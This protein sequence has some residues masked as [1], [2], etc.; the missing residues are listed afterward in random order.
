[1]TRVVRLFCLVAGTFVCSMMEVVS[2]AATPKD[3]VILYED[4]AR[5]GYEK[6]S[7]T[8]MEGAV[9]RPKRPLSAQS[10]DTLFGEQVG[11]IVRNCSTAQYRCISVWSRIFAVPRNR[12]A[13]AETY[14][15]A[16]ASL[17]VEDCLRGDASVCQVA[18]ISAD[19]QQMSGEVCEEVKGGRGE[20]SKPG[21]IL[22]FIYN[23]DVGVTAYGVTDKP[24]K[25][26]NQRL[27]VASQMIL[28]GQK[29]LLAERY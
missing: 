20:S 11:H 16:G 6:F 13:P 29:G 10:V 22:Y 24:A 27:D 21:P 3:R 15:V 26:K 2:S 14:S 1:M 25:T 8:S 28:Q 9:V 4:S 17:K 5:T 12:L 19:C 7:D 23:E 18:V